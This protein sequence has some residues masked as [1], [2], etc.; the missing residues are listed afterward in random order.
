MQVITTIAEMQELAERSKREGRTVGCVPTMGSLHNGHGS[1]IAASAQHHAVTVTSVFVN[2][3]QFGP[4][5][6]YDSYPRDLDGD[7]EKIREHGGTHVFAPSVAEMYP[8]GFSTSIRV[9]DVTEVLEGARRPG[10]FDGVATV[11]C[12]LLEA[13][14][15][16]E[17]YF[18]QKD[19]QQTLVVKRMVRDLFLPVRIT[20]MPT[21]READGLAMSSRNAYLSSDE[22]KKATILF[23]ALQAARDLVSDTDD[24]ISRQAIEHAMTHTLKQVPELVPEYAVAV[25][26]DTLREQDSYATGDRIAL[27]IASKLGTTRLIDNFVVTV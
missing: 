7:I 17:A 27:L 24:S 10:H 1:L 21:V 23:Q 18:G 6:D 14:R 15:P 11:V 25:D 20:V 2:P 13:M 8:E 3:T 19:Y 12:K 22:R 5:E 26:A 4:N 16:T 9:G